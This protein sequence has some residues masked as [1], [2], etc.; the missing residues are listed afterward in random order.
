MRKYAYFL[1]VTFTLFAIASCGDGKPDLSKLTVIGT[2][3]EDK[4]ISTDEIIAMSLE[5]LRA[6]LLGKEVTIT[7]LRDGKRTG[8]YNIEKAQCKVSYSNRRNYPEDYEIKSIWVRVYTNG[9]PKFVLEDS[10]PAETRAADITYSKEARLPQ[11]SCNKKC[12][13]EDAED[14]EQCYYHSPNTVISGKVIGVHKDHQNGAP[15]I[16]MKA[17]G[18]AY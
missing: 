16:S 7:G 18:I 11:S 4:Y 15:F 13:W 9:F 8:G 5:Q 17:K 10:I 12:T 14:K 2:I 3:D 1:F 6:D